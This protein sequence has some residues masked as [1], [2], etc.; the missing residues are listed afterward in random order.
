MSEGPLVPADAAPPEAAEPAAPTVAEPAPTTAPI[1]EPEATAPPIAEPEV[2][3]LPIAE[4]EPPAPADAAPEP[5][6]LSVATPPADEPV[7]TGSATAA[8]LASAVATRAPRQNGLIAAA[9]VL[10]AASGITVIWSLFPKFGT[11][12]GSAFSLSGTPADIVQVMIT[13]IAALVASVLLAAPRT[14]RLIGPGILLGLATEGLNSVVLDIIVVHY[15]PPAGPGMWLNVVGGLALTAAA[16]L[17]VVSLARASAVRLGPKVQAG[18]LP[19]LVVLIGAVSAIVLI[20][21]VLREDIIPGVH[22]HYAAQIGFSLIWSSAMTL[23]VPAAAMIVLPRSFGLALLAGGLANDIANAAFYTSASNSEFSV[24][25]LILLVL[26]IV[27][28][29]RRPD[30]SAPAPTGPAQPA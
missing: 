29:V 8:P 20:V 15:N 14:R 7:A 19:R 26:A 13:G 25:I 30:R 1:A 2:T 23:A 3:A 11:V 22:A 6:A 12:S 16:I 18:L 27:L 21:L 24:L 28:A 9:A 10:S 4:P 17:V 5:A